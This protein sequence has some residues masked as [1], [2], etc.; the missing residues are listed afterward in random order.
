MQKN[1]KT[2]FILIIA[3]LLFISTINAQILNIENKRFYNDTN[4]FVGFARFKFNV[5]HNTI[6][7]FEYGNSI[8]MQYQKNKFRTLFFLDNQF[9]KVDTQFF[10]NSGYFHL[11][12]SYKIHPRITIEGFSQLQNNRLLKLNL[13]FLTGAGPRFKLLDKENFKAYIA[14]IPMYEY[15]INAVDANPFKTIRLS[16]Y[17]TMSLHINE[18]LFVNS[19]TY[20]QPNLQNTA[21]YRLSE[22]VSA[23]F[24][25]KKNIVLRSSFNLLYDTFQPTGVPSL[26]YRFE[27]GLEIHF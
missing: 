11:R 24:T 3:S 22:D 18:I 7:V 2:V 26:S 25:I 13:R 14:S 23:N 15:E 9:S 19:T 1:Y 21:D 6:K 17:Y 5:T 12:L 20:F 8:Q 4:T 16:N 27:N 10:A